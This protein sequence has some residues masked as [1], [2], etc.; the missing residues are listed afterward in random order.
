MMDLIK[1]S[2]IALKIDERHDG[3]A[4]ETPVNFQSDTKSF[5]CALSASR[6]EKNIRFAA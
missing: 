1:K 4:A 5:I 3:S 2:M 6:L